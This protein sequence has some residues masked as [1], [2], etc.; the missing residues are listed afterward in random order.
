M[1]NPEHM[2]IQPVKESP[3]NE[4]AEERLSDEFQRVKEGAI[5]IINKKISQIE[6]KLGADAP[7][8]AAYER[9]KIKLKKN[10]YIVNLAEVNRWQDLLDRVKS[11][12]EKDMQY[13][14]LAQGLANS[15]LSL[16]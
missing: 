15:A 2:E 14:L 16:H 3:E 7:E 13:K 10:Q 8:M 6:E 4:Q 1:M 12:E 5:E 9:A 11:Q